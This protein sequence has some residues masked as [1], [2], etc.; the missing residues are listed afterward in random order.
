MEKGSVG[1]YTIVW[2]ILFFYWQML[3][4][5]RKGVIE[6]II[7]PIKEEKLCLLQQTH[8]DGCKLV[9]LERK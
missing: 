6:I 8:Y 1:S 4:L 2:Q 3:L 9:F 5:I 7:M